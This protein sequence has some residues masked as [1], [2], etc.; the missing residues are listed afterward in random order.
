MR[1]ATT[2]ILF[3][4]LSLRSQ[5]QIRVPDTGDGWKEVVDSA[6]LLVEK[7]DT[8]AHRILV[9]NCEEVEFALA[10][11]STTRPPRTIVISVKD[12]RTR[13]LNNIAC[14]LVHESYHLYLGKLNP[15]LDLNEEEYLCY[16]QEYSFIMK[17]KEIEDWLFKNTLDMLLYHKSKSK[18]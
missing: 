10:P 16:L 17:L 14:V 18:N 3:F 7:T 9:E 1:F 5:A 6:I 4:L 15:S 12:M 13:S 8:S 2:V 11:F